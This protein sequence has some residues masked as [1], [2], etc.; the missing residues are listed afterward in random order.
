MTTTRKIG[1]A[2]AVLI[3]LFVAFNLVYFMPRATMGRIT[4]TEVK[5]VDRSSSATG[6]EK[7]RDVRYVYATELDSGK[8][9][10]FRNEDNAFYLKFD[11]GDVAAEAS[12]LASNDVDEIALIQYYGVRVALF[13]AYPNVIS[14]KEVDADYV[15]VPWVQMV[16][17]V[18]LLIGFIWGGVKLRKAFR[19]AKEKIT[20]RP[21]AS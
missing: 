8:A 13:H 9:I 2:V 7:T 10:V 6:T 21:A 11:S 19:A 20:N 5:R 15:Y 3:A 14:I 1:V 12:K 18:L 4:G 16:V 17:L